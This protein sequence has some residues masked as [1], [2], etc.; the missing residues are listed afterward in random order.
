MARDLHDHYFRLAKREGYRSRAAYKLIEIDD[1][2]KVLRRGDRVLDCG[3]APG[4]WLQVAS[5][6]VGPKGVVVGVDPKPI[7]RGSLESIVR[8]LE[9]GL[10][11]IDDETLRVA[12]SGERR[13]RFNVILSDM[14]P[15]TTGNWSIDH[16]TSL[17]LCSM[18][19]DRCAALLEP[20]GN[21]VMKVFE[22]EGYPDLLARARSMFETV[23]G[24][25]PAASRNESREMFIIAK[26]YRGED[27]VLDADS[28][29][30]EDGPP[31]PKR[32]PSAGWR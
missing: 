12:G 7:A 18:L 13:E 28:D 32:K 23:K 27:V 31:P 16:P 9:G 19:L 24:F 3:S 11:S 8:L 22:G 30:R 26:G 14:A 29:D 17:R 2:R 1:K 20:G 6:R 10:E 15:S 5:Q 21:L 4:S 25:R